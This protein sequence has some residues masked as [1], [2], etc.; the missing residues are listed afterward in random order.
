VAYFLGGCHRLDW[1]DSLTS[2]G[3]PCYTAGGG[4]FYWPMFLTSIN[5]QCEGTC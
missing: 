3:Q 1:V 5:Q 4:M 2:R